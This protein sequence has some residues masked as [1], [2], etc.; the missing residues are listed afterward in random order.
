MVNE[1]TR[2]ATR[3]GK[4][5]KAKAHTKRVIGSIRAGNG[6]MIGNLGS[7]IG[8]EEIEAT[9]RMQNVS[10]KKDRWHG[11]IHEIAEEVGNLLKI[12]RKR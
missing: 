5:D 7:M 1:A 4:T 12:D 3:S 11:D 2:A 10:G 8:N 6:S 9:S